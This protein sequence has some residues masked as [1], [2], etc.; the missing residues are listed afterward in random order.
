MDINIVM[1]GINL[2]PT[3][4]NSVIVVLVVSLFCMI[5]GM[6]IKKADPT[7]PTKGLVLVMEVVFSSLSSFAEESIGRKAATHVPFILTLAFYL[8]VANLLGLTG[9]TPPTSDFSI[10]LALTIVTLVYIF[11]SGVITKG[12]GRHM[13]DTYKGNAPWAIT[14]INVVGEFSKIIS[15][16]VRLFGNIA[17][18]V[19]ILALLT[20]ML[21]WVALP[22]V[23]FLNAYF[24]VFAGVMQ[25]AIFCILTMMWLRG[26]T[27]PIT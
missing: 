25:T 18:G 9:L 26:A 27:E 7:K 14:I 3:I 4:I 1:N 17:S 19:V 5:C 13:L 24:D 22:I 8:A 21:G 15:L 12:I 10:T 2:S 11:I 16:S 20:H 6:K 23:P